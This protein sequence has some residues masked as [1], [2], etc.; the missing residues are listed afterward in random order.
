M[1]GG[2]SQSRVSRLTQSFIKRIL[3]TLNARHAVVRGLS[4]VEAQLVKYA[5]IMLTYLQLNRDSF[6]YCAA[7]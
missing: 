2:Y 7:Y 3:T 1:G 6:C 5:L 4:V